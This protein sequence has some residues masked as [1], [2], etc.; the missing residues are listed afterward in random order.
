MRPGL[1]NPKAAPEAVRLY[2]YLC[3]IEGRG[4]LAGQQEHPA[5]H[6]QGSDLRYIK[7]VSGKLPAIRGLDYIHNDFDS[8]N[9]RAK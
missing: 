4:I 7:A 5:K 8:V 3:S 1:S 2:E 9:R 6:H